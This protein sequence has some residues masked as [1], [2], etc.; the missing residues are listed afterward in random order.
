MCPVLLA[1][2]GPQNIWI[3]QSSHVLWGNFLL[4]KTGLHDW[5]VWQKKEINHPL[6]RLV[7]Y[8]RVCVVLDLKI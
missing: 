6:I 3:A 1:N 4:N 2:I 5:T 7:L 8:F